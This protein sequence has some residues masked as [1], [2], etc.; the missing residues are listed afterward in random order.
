MGGCLIILGTSFF[1]FSADHHRGTHELFASV[2]IIDLC[3][4]QPLSKWLVLIQYH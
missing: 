3:K 4:L 1:K 2:Q